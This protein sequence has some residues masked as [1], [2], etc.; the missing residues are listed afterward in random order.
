M[1]SKEKEE[2]ILEVMILQ[3]LEYAKRLMEK[4]IDRFQQIEIA[5]KL[6]YHKHPNYR[7]KIVPLHV[8]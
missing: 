6:L 3:E 5:T 2:E 7:E 1:L 4:A 8:S